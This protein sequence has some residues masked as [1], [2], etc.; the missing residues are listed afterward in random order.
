LRGE[1]LAHGIARGSIDTRRMVEITVELLDALA[2]AHRAGLVH[3]DIKPENVF[4]ARDASGNQVD[5]RSDIFSVGGLLFHGLTGRTPFEGTNYNILVVSIMTTRAPYLRTVR[6]DIPPD[7]AAVVDAALEPDAAARFASADAMKN[8]LRACKVPALAP[9][10]ADIALSQTLASEEATAGETPG[11]IAAAS[12]LPAG[13]TAPEPTATPPAQTPP[14][15]TVPRTA[16]GGAAE[17]P[18]PRARWPLVAVGLLAAA[19][20]AVGA[21]LLLRPSNDTGPVSDA[22]PPVA[23]VAVEPVQAMVPV[24]ANAPAEQ[25]DE[26]PAEAVMAAEEAAAAEEAEEEAERER[27]RRAR[28]RREK[29]AADEAAAAAQSRC[30]SAC[31]MEFHHCVSA[32]EARGSSEASLRCHQQSSV[33]RLRCG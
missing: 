28:A 17:Q 2:A 19:A 31:A 7:L 16:Y 14:G 15:L 11:A 12:H 10:P 9:P 33:C 26:A 27:A 4:L 13:T 3:R 1:S 30:M 22:P 5:A 6:Q 8:A 23:G 20:G 32:P 21:V 29:Q 25:P 18:K 24:E